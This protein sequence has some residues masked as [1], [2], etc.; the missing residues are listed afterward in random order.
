MA[1][2]WIAVAEHVRIGRV[3]GFMQVCHG[4]CGPLRRTALEEA[5]ADLCQ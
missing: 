2:A 4:T 3:A 5:G 1:R